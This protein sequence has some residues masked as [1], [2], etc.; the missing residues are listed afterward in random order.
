MGFL[1]NAL[2]VLLVITGVLIIAL[3]LMHRGRGGG[4]SDMFGGGI[5]AGLSSSGSGQQFLD[6]VTWGV[7]IVFGMVVV[8]LGLV[9][10]YAE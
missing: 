2:W 1:T 7:I 4:M 5:G 6:R 10:K 9:A 3:V 8:L